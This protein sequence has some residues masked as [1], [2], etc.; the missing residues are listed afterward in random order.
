[1][2]WLHSIYTSSVSRHQ[3]APVIITC[4]VLTHHSIHKDKLPRLQFHCMTTLCV[5]QSSGFAGHYAR[6]VKQQ[7][8]RLSNQYCNW[9]VNTSAALYKLCY[10]NIHNNIQQQK[11]Q[12]KTKSNRW[13][14]SLPDNGEL[15]VPLHIA[16]ALADSAANVSVTVAPRASGIRNNSPL[17]TGFTSHLAAAIIANHVISSHYIFYFK[18]FFACKLQIFIHIPLVCNT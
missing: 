1:M 16:E 8:T 6:H 2:V 17:Y 4:S 14:V 3:R 13:A 10:I 18:T 9:W 11:Q 12:H 5:R 7:T 15:Y